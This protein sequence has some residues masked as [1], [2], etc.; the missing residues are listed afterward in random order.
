M[1]EGKAGELGDG[2][3]VAHHLGHVEECCL[4]SS[5]TTRHQSSRRMRQE[6]ICFVAHQLHRL[7]LDK[8]FIVFVVYRRGPSQHHLVVLETFCRLYH[9]R[10]I[11]LDFLQSATSQQ[12]Q[13]RAMAVQ[14]VLPAEL[15]KSL[16]ISSPE[17]PHLLSRRIAHIMDGIMMLLLIEGHLERQDGEHLGNVALDASDTPFLPGPNLG[18]DIVISGDIRLLFQELSDIQVEAGII[19]QDDNIRLPFD[20]ILLTQFH[21]GE[22]RT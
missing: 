8:T 20:D 14:V 19:H 21:V 18:R 2:G 7:P 17:F 4:Q 10:Q 16:R 13:Y 15:S 22:N 1:I 12:S 3:L 11:V 6:R 5:R 9:R